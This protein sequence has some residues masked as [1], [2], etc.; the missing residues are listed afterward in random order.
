MLRR[1][2]PLLT[3]WWWGKGRR[4]AGKLEESYNGATTWSCLRPTVSF[5][6]SN[7]SCSAPGDVSGPHW[8]SWPLHTHTQCSPGGQQTVMDTGERV[9][10]VK[11]EGV[12]CPQLMFIFVVANSN[13]LRS[14]VHLGNVCEWMWG[15]LLKDQWVYWFSNINSDSPEWFWF[16]L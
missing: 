10:C 13:F 1:H 8:G 4:L 6:I 16:Y 3:Q 9:V 14:V 11:A 5:Q 7:G 12:L 15:E 2:R